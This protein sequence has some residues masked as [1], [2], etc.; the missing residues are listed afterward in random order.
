[1]LTISLIIFALYTIS[2]IAKESVS[3]G[4]TNIHKAFN[5]KSFLSSKLNKSFVIVRATSAEVIRLRRCDNSDDTLDL[6]AST[7]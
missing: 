2:S 1:M 4:Y 5:T 3:V 7:G 6:K